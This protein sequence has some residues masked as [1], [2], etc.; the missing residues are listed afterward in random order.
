MREKFERLNTLR[1]TEAEKLLSDYKRA[2]T[3]QKQSTSLSM[4]AAIY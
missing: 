1:T 3:A 4:S 2:F